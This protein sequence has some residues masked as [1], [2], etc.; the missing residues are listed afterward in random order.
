MEV[1]RNGGIIMK[2]NIYVEY[3]GSKK[4]QKDFIAKTKEIWVSMGN[5]IKDINTLDLYVKPE[6]LTVY[7]VINED[8]KGSFPFED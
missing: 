4:E 5:K 1:Y 6:E 2:S 3:Q 7:Y 8:T